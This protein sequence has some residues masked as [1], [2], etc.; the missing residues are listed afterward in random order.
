M[1]KFFSIYLNRKSESNLI[2]IKSELKRLGITPNRFFQTLMLPSKL[3]LKEMKDKRDLF[4][5]NFGPI[6]IKP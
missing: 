1:S 4:N 5:G 2:E 3:R 6:R